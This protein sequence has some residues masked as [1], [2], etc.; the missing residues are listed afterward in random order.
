MPPAAFTPAARADV[1]LA[2]ASAEARTA[3]YGDQVL[4]TIRQAVAAVEANPLMFGEV[5]PGCCACMTRRFKF[6]VYY[7][8]HPVDRVV[9]IAVRHGH[10]DP[11]VWQARLP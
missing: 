1:G 8:V 7:E 11:A 5:R 6:V 2:R 10:D 9:V 3:G 4:E